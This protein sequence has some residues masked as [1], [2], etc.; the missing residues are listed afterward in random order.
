[1]RMCGNAP[2]MCACI[3]LRYFCCVHNQIF[4]MCVGAPCYLTYINMTFPP[5]SPQCCHSGDSD[6]YR[7]PGGGGCARHLPYSL[8]TPTGGQELRHN[9]GGRA[10][11]GRLS[12]QYHSQSY[13]GKGK[14]GETE[15]KTVGERQGR[16]K[17]RK[18]SVVGTRCW[19]SLKGSK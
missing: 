2:I 15:N 9:Q 19:N 5:R 3:Q 13:G 6:L 11:L 4:V 8:D 17:G 1:M 16:N 12:A 7:R 10:G 18:V 14:R